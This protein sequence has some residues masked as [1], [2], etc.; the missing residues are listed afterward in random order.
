[1]TKCSVSIV[2]YMQAEFIREAVES[3]LSQ[4]TDFGVEVI[5]G[6]DAST[7]GTRE[8][9]EEMAAAHPD[10]LR[11]ILADRNYGDYGLTNVMATIRA[12]RGEYIAF[13]DGDDYWTDPTKLQR[14]IDFMDAHPD[15]DVSAHRVRH[16]GTGIEDYLSVRP[17]PGDRTWPFA[18]LLNVNFTPK[19]ATVIRR[20]ALAHLPDWYATTRVASAA[21]LFNLLVAD[22]KPVG[23]IDDVMAAHRLHGANLTSHYGAE[24]MLVDKLETFA[25]LREAVPGARGAIRLAEAKVRLRLALMRH[26][27]GAYGMAKRGFNAMLSRRR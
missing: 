25:L 19:S 16:V 12:A 21:W 8:I 7:D 18:R 5:V 26:S 23:F 24:R 27:P 13:L 9:V 6:D 2:T 15:C 3:A 17:G 11:P 20:S 4:R 22:G 1:M 14:Q 10:R